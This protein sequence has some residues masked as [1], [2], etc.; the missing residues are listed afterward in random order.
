MKDFHV[1]PV[2]LESAQ[3]LEDIPEDETSIEKFRRIARKVASETAAGRWGEV[4]R[5]VGIETCSQIGRCRS[6]DSFKNQQ[7]LQKA[8]DEAKRLVSRSP[9]PGRAS[10]IEI[11]DPTA[12]TLLELLKNITEEIGDLSPADTLHPPK[13]GGNRNASPLHHLGAQLQIMLSRNPSPYQT[14]KLEKDKKDDM[15]PGKPPLGSGPSTRSTMKPSVTQNQSNLPTSV[16]SSTG[17]MSTPP[18]LC[19]KK[20]YMTVEADINIVESPVPTPTQSPPPEI[21]ITKISPLRKQQSTDHL[22]DIE[23]EVNS[24]NRNEEHSALGSISDHPPRVIKRKA[25]AP[26]EIG[27]QRPVLQ[28]AAT[29]QAMVPPPP[30]KLD[31]TNASSMNIPI[32]SATP[33][34]P[35]P[36][37]KIEDQSNTRSEKE[38]QPR[39][40]ES[41]KPI[42]CIGIDTSCLSDSKEHL[43][44]SPDRPVTTKQRAP[45]P[46]C[47]RA[48]RKVEDVKTVKRQLKDGW[49]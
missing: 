18:K 26:A 16:T 5:G 43:M 24:C 8:M 44:S 28:K 20:D 48:Y 22:I 31:G 38:E 37:K 35:L 10:P 34:T 9:L 1:A 17:F 2:D 3:E 29:E 49:L 33:P 7:N 12:N 19:K 45:S 27:I 25:P 14:A 42:M 41:P 36:G 39:L 32:L 15:L 21:K 40:T 30:C 47:L 23:P 46:E 6:R 4:I 11:I 13:D